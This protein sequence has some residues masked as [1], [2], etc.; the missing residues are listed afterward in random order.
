[1][2][3]ERGESSNSG[4]KN[5]DTKLSVKIVFLKCYR[6]E[7]TRCT[8]LMRILSPGLKVSLWSMPMPTTTAE[9]T[10]VTED[11][12][13]APLLNATAAAAVERVC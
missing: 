4:L 8:V 7:I 3:K 1:M 13:P 5:Q 9:S 10:V 6:D 2:Y 12:P 11:S